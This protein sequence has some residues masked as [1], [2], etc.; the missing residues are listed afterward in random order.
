MNYSKIVF[1]LFTTYNTSIVANL[2]IKI[3]KL[4]CLKLS[5]TPGNHKQ[6]FFVFYISV[7]TSVHYQDPYENYVDACY[8]LN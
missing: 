6:Y 4:T 7:L 8:D 3:I 2:G 1:R 5:I